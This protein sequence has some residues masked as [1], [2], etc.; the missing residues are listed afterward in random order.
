MSDNVTI[1]NGS[2]VIINAKDPNP[3]KEDKKEEK[4]TETKETPVVDKEAEKSPIPDNIRILKVEDKEFL[5]AFKD[6]SLELEANK[7]LL[8]EFAKNNVTNSVLVNEVYNAYMLAYKLYENTKET[9][10]TE[11]VTKQFP[12]AINFDLNFNTGLVVIT[13]A[14]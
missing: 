10:K 8:L 13:L 5:K 3:K 4:A 1:K 9:F 11:V 14:Q 2:D 12:N 6:C 7:S